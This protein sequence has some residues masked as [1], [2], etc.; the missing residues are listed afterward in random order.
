MSSRLVG[1]KAVRLHAN[2]QLLCKALEHSLR[3]HLTWCEETQWRILFEAN[4]GGH[5]FDDT[6]VEA[7]L[8]STRAL[9]LS[10]G[11][12]VYLE[13]LRSASSGISTVRMFVLYYSAAMCSDYL[14][15]ASSGISLLNKLCLRRSSNASIWLACCEICAI[16]SKPSSRFI[17]SC[18]HGFSRAQL[19]SRQDQGTS[20]CVECK[21]KYKYKCTSKCKYKYSPHLPYARASCRV[22]RA[23]STPAQR[24]CFVY[25]LRYREHRPD[26]PGKTPC[27]GC[28][29]HASVGSEWQQ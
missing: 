12:E 23:D 7:T 13:Y 22:T 26:L 14:R 21:Y 6:V 4:R 16:A 8:A 3:N 11:A 2:R 29:G 19:A 1:A 20:T 5:T 25:L 15:S 18:T 9:N 24:R 17:M 28:G 27:P 10:S